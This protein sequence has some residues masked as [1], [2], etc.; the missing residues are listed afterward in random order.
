MAKYKVK[1]TNIMHG[2]QLYKEGSIIEL[3]ENEAKR[4]ADFLEFVSETKTE[5]GNKNSAKT[6]T[7]KSD[8]NSTKAKNTTTE[9]PVNE[10]SDGGN[11]DGK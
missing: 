5:S 8:K 11:A 9:A 7:S 2:K 4:L 10:V 6:T 1:H 3:T